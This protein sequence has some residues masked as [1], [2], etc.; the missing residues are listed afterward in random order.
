MPTIQVGQQTIYFR[1]SQRG[2]V[3]NA[4]PLV[5]VHGAGG[6]HMHW[7][8][9]L[10]RLAATTVYALDLPGH[11]QSPG[12]GCTTITDYAQTVIAWADA[13]ELP[14][15]VLAGHSMGGAI[16]QTAALRQPERLAGLILVGTGARL[17]VSPAI[18]DGL[19]RD[20]AA[21][22]RLIAEWAYKRQAAPA[23]IDAYVDAMLKIPVQVTH[24]DF[25]ACNTFDLTAEVSQ[26]QVPTLVIVGL[27]DRLT[28]PKLSRF[29]AQ[30]M[31][32][33]RLLE[34]AEAGHM[35]MLEQSAI[36]TG[37]VHEF[38]LTLAAAETVR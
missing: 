31:A 9:E 4:P 22:A 20:Y 21:T 17:F 38:L 10:R 1:R 7:P 37:A 26:I 36:V 6:T 34:V 8:A 19:S 2:N 28:P 33:A 30:Q 16:A 11:G 15:F 3:S 18:L 25:I 12:A 27:E 13:L 29:L 14:G 35:V 32:A 5:L 23:V 24:D